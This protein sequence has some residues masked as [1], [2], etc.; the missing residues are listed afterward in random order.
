M[1]SEERKVQE[2]L[3]RPIVDQLGNEEDADKLEKEFI[4]NQ[5]LNGIS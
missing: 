3:E 5:H 4:D 2:T 1:K